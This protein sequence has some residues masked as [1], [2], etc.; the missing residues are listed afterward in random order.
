MAYVISMNTLYSLLTYCRL[1]VWS[2]SEIM[3]TASA[4]ANLAQSSQSW[5]DVIAQQV[6]S[7]RFGMVQI[8]VHD[9]KVV[10]I[11]RTEKIRFPETARPNKSEHA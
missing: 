11:E 7:L 8:I 10:Q 6:R 2:Q 9:S 3:E 1:S 5:T 4:A